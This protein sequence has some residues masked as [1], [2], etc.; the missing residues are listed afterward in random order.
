M[1][2]DAADLAACHALLRQGSR[3]FHAASRLLPGEVR[4]AVVALYAFCRVADD[5]VDL[6]GGPAAALLRLRERLALAYAGCPADSPADRCFAAL[7]A[8]HGIPRTLPEALL[9][10]FQWDIEGRRYETL[11]ALEAYGARVA[12]SV[13]VMMALLMGVRAPAA[14]ARA[15]DLGVAMQLTNIARDVGEDARNGRVYLPEAWLREAGV[16][17]EALLADPAFSPALGQVAQRLLYAAA[18]RYQAAEPG[19]ALLPLAC[20]PAILAAR[21][22]YAEIGT[23]VAGR[24]GD[25]VTAR[26]VVPGRRKLALLAR[27]LVGAGFLRG[28]TGAPPLPANAFLV[29]AVPAPQLP[30]LPWWQLGARWVRVLEM[31]AQPGRTQP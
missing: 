13:G 22:I 9:E 31:L 8:R 2:P 16:A 26:A 29:R 5:A 19:I 21:L 6:G 11:E 18:A 14:L 4:D 24:G 20:R 12:G 25:S 1:L 17:P 30:A 3:S 28:A 23:V 7:V 10:G 27:A 15:A